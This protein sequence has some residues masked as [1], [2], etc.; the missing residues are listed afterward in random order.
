MSDKFLCTTSWFI[1]IKFSKILHNTNE[2]VPIM[3]TLKNKTE[4]TKEE[5][6]TYETSKQYFEPSKQ[7]IA[8]LQTL[9]PHSRTIIE[10]VL[11]ELEVSHLVPSR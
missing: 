1:Q 6:F 7:Y 2:L 8:K 4:V 5:K 10:H 11:I 3:F 9:T